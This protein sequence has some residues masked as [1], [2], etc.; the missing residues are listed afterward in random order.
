MNC[1]LEYTQFKIYCVFLITDIII[2]FY[3]HACI[4]LD[5]DWLD[6]LFHIH[7]KTKRLGDTFKDKENARFKLTRPKLLSKSRKTHLKCWL[8]F[9]FSV[10]VIFRVYWHNCVS[11]GTEK[12]FS[13]EMFRHQSGIATQ[14]SRLWKFR[15]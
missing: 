2:I 1:P 12:H 7:I 6:V 5:C 9:I 10:S 13:I 11:I 15:F 14:G 8:L 3:S 4:F